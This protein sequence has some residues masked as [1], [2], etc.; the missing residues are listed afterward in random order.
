MY[1]E[2]HCILVLLELHYQLPRTE[3]SPWEYT[4]LLQ[5]FLYVVLAYDHLVSFCMHKP[6]D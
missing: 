5:N 6:Y 3:N 4:F 2:N 1:L